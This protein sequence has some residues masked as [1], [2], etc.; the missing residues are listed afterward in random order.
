ME[1]ATEGDGFAD[2]PALRAKYGDDALR[3]PSQSITKVIEP[4]AQ[5]GHWATTIAHLPTATTP[6][7]SGW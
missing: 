4:S 3:G 6:D 5:Q 1:A 7:S 2:G